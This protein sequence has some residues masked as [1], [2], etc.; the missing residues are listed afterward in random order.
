[1]GVP[2]GVD[3]GRKSAV[4]NGAGVA[5][6]GHHQRIIPPAL[7]LSAAE[8]AAALGCFRIALL[9]LA[10]DRP[11]WAVAGS[12][13]PGRPLVRKE[14]VDWFEAGLIPEPLACVRRGNN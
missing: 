1:M 9:Q 6:D 7:G 4:V 2:Y 11:A 5:T 13:G 3:A 8:A 14:L 10:P 12:H